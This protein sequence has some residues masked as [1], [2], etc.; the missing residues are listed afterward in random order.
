MREERYQVGGHTF[1]PAMANGV[2]GKIN[3]YTAL[4][5]FRE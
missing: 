4:G 3:Y 5:S 2:F 1:F